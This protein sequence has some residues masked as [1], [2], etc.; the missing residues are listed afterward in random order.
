MAPLLTMVHHAHAAPSPG[1]TAVSQKLRI[2]VAMRTPP[3]ATRSWNMNA[4]TRHSAM[5]HS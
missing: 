4:T 3:N 2:A 1:G 5:A